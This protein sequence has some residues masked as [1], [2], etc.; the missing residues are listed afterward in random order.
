MQ[1]QQLKSLFSNILFETLMKL[2]VDLI[3]DFCSAI[4]IVEQY[5]NIKN[6][7][8]LKANHDFNVSFS[9]FNTT[10]LGHKDRYL[11]LLTYNNKVAKGSEKFTD[12]ITFIELAIK[13]NKDYIIDDAKLDIYLRER[14]FYMIV[15]YAEKDDVIM[16]KECLDRLA[17]LNLLGK[18]VEEHIYKIITPAQKLIPIKSVEMLKLLNSYTKN[19]Y[20]TRVRDDPLIFR[21]AN[22]DLIV[23]LF[24]NFVI[25]KNGDEAIKEILNRGNIDIFNFMATRIKNIDINSL[26][27]NI[28]STNDENFVRFV[29]DYYKIQPS[30]LDSTNVLIYAGKTKN[31]NFFIKFFIEYNNDIDYKKLFLN[32]TYYASIDILKFIMPFFEITNEDL[33]N[34]LIN[35]RYREDV[36]ETIQY[37]IDYH[38]E[39]QRKIYQT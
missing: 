33:T 37:F 17:N 31:L 24:T 13:Q 39:Y 2:D 38:L 11:Q 29:L 34:L 28:Y 15:F 36:L 19:K 14:I 20:E 30:D 23:Y 1:Q 25:E 21:S 4:K 27:Y 8:A 16:V 18:S 22:F 7:W 5:C 35:S 3:P 9:E 32:S 10:F 26:I 6:F 12:A